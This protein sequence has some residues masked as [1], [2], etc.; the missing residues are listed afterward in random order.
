MSEDCLGK[1]DKTLVF[2][3]VQYTHLLNAHYSTVFCDF[4][5]QFSIVDTTG[6]TPLQGMIVSIVSARI[7][8]AVTF[9]N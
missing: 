7:Y 3:Y 8:I 6:E 4:G 9:A 1:A 5:T 2:G